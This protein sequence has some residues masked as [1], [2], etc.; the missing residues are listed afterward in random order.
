M[1]LLMKRVFS[2]SRIGSKAPLRVRIWRAGL[3]LA[4]L[5]ASLI[6]SALAAEPKRILVLHSFGKDFRPWREYATHLRSELIEKSP[7]PLDIIEY[8][9][10]SARSS[11]E[12][13]EGP[14]AVY[15]RAL[16]ESHPPDLI[17]GIG[18]PAA[19]FVQ[20]QR[21]HLFKTTPLLLTAIEARR[22]QYSGLTQNDTVVAVHH[23]FVVLFENILRVLPNTKNIVVVNGVSPNERFWKEEITRETG[24]LQSRVEIT[25]T[26]YQ[27][28][29]DTLKYAAGLPPNSAIFLFQ[30]Q[31]DSAGVVHEGDT[32]LRRLYAVA[33]API[34][35]TDEAFFGRELV[36]GPMHSVAVNNA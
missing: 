18:A 33:N 11:N 36:G 4:V 3:L 23:D 20:R 34:F 5:A 22:V 10:V 8:S 26:D 17:I 28:F 2:K 6:C 27:S 14:F 29:E 1:F 25:W 21:E 7:W 19:G 24:P 30:M 12:N 15:L 16:F 9:L 13:S 35:S 32:A 31:L